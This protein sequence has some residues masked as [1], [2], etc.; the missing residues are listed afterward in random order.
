MRHLERFGEKNREGDPLQ[1]VSGSSSAIQ[2]KNESQTPHLG[3]S[4]LVISDVSNSSPTKPLSTPNAHSL[5]DHGWYN[6]PCKRQL[7]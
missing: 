1:A 6:Y 2:Q 5:S 3:I 7:I 4:Y